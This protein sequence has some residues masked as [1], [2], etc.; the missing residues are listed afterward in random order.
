MATRARPSAI[1]PVGVVTLRGNVPASVIQTD[2]GR[3][4]DSIHCVCL[5]ISRLAAVELNSKYKKSE[6]QK[7]APLSSPEKEGSEA[8]TVESAICVGRAI[9]AAVYK[10]TSGHNSPFKQ[11]S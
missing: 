3:G 11:D 1:Q 9:R 8:D 5:W 7:C 6:G 10:E 2:S 4:S